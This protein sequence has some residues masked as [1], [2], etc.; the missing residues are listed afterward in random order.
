LDRGTSGVV[1]LAKNPAAL[2]QAQA[3]WPGAQKTYWAVVRGRYGGPPRI[4]R[5]L[6]D[7]DGVPRPAVTEVRQMVGLGRFEATVLEVALRTGRTHQIRKHLAQVGHPILLDDR[8][9]DFAANK[10]LQRTMRG[11]SLRAPRKGELFLHA[12]ELRLSPLEL[13]VRA[14]PPAAWDL[15]LAAGDPEPKLERWPD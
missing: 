15:L 5:P 9:G 10:A 2:K 12:R 6:P 3:A 13:T 4:D 8:Y 14:A 7:E 1:L 11:M